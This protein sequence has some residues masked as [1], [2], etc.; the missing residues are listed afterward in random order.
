MWWF[1]FD[2]AHAGDISP[3]MMAQMRELQVLMPSKARSN[4]LERWRQDDVY[5][6]IAYV[7]SEVADMAA[8]IARVVR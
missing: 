1:G 4:V 7:R 5:R 8:Q 3:A 6:D 2:C